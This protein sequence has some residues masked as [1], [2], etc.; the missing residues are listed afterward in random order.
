MTSGKRAGGLDLPADTWGSNNEA[1]DV[2]PQPSRFPPAGVP[3]SEARLNGSARIA[4]DMERKTPI[5]IAIVGVGNCAS[6]LVQGIGFYADRANETGLLRPE[7]GGYRVDDLEI[8]AAFDIDARKIGRPV[9]EAIFALPNRCSTASHR[10]WRIIRSSGG[11][12][13]PI[14]RRWMSPTR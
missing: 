2:G 14:F 4:K 12:S 1:T 10:T 5:R 6:S 11:L 7:I 13:R 9:K 3:A 8:V